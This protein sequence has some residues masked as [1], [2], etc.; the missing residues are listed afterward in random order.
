MKGDD[1]V[2]SLIEAV[3]PLNRAQITFKLQAKMVQCS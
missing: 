3:M 1:K 2:M